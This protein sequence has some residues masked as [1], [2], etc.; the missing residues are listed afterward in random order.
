MDHEKNVT[1]AAAALA[2]AIAAARAAGYR[3]G[4]PDWAL[5]GLTVSETGKVAPPAPSVDETPPV[6]VVGRRSPPPA[7]A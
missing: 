2:E 4:F 5:K 6:A 1:A 7:A 3:I